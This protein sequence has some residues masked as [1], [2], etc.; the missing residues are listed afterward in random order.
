[1]FVC[2]FA[3]VKVLMSV[4]GCPY[5]CMYFCVP[6]LHTVG[7][8]FVV[9]QSWIDQPVIRFCRHNSQRAFFTTAKRWRFLRPCRIGNIRLFQRRGFPPPRRPAI[10]HGSAD[11]YDIYRAASGTTRLEHPQRLRHL[12]QT[13][14]T[15]HVAQVWLFAKVL[16]SGS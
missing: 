13:Q 4:F 15:L 9:V 8:L 7:Q 5:A 16:S 12:E 14:G 11:S 1:M 6:V 10:S 2:T 3:K